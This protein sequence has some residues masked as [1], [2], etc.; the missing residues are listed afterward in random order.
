MS[1]RYAPLIGGIL[2]AVAAISSCGENSASPS[3]PTTVTSRIIGITISAPINEY[4]PLDLDIGGTATLTANATHSDGTSALLSD[5]DWNS[6]NAT[7]A[8]VDTQGTVTAHAVGTT[9][10]TASKDGHYGSASVNVTPT[11][12]LDRL[13]V[14]AEQKTL[15]VGDT[16][17]VTLT[18]HYSDG[19]QQQVTPTWSSRNTAVATVTASG[20]VTGLAEGTAVIRGSYEGRNPSVT[21]TVIPAVSLESVFIRLGDTTLTVGETTQAT[22]EARYSDGS[23]EYVTATWA[24]MKSSVATI[25]SSGMVTAVGTGTAA[26]RGRYEGKEGYRDVTVS[27][28]SADLAWLYM[29][30][31]ADGT[32]WADIQNNGSGCARNVSWRF[33]TF[34]DKA[35]NLPLDDV[36]GSLASS[37]TITPGEQFTIEGNDLDESVGYGGVYMTLD[38]NWSNVSCSS[39]LLPHD[40]LVGGQQL[41]GNTESQSSG[42]TLYGYLTEK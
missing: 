2:V 13:V 5:A 4:L 30:W 39:T 19:S 6:T 27:V 24:S 37:R 14:T 8:S 17:T 21:I 10:I 28:L 3:A 33:R 22:A 15:R 34:E 7:V 1:G 31:V 23:K 42:R 35:R 41:D 36:T 26:I 20:K 12:A 40:A 9:T 38:I 18:A 11:V 32:Y 25:S 16:T 29:E